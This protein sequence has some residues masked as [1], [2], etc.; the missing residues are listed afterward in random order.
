MN[1]I[2]DKKD[3]TESRSRNKIQERLI[4]LIQNLDQKDRSLDPEK[5]KRKWIFV[6]GGLFILY[7]LSFFV[8]TKKLSHQ[9]IEPARITVP[10]DADPD[11]PL[12]TQKSMTFEMPVD[13]FETVLKKQINEK[14]PKKK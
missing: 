1:Q 9:S 12:K 14:L 5:R 8:S 11:K 4:H 6:L 3:I 2:N 10:A 7:M 13:S